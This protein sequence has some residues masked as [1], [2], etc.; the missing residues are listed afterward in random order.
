VRS[1]GIQPVHAIAPDP[2]DTQYHSSITTL[3]DH[4][5][6]TTLVL[7]GAQHAARSISDQD[8]QNSGTTK[9]ATTKNQSIMGRPSFQ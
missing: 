5:S 3:V 8:D 6:I 7:V 2:I 1:R 4:S 9:V